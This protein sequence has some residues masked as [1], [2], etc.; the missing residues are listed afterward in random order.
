MRVSHYP[1]AA[2]MFDDAKVRTSK[3]HYIRSM[4]NTNENKQPHS[5]ECDCLHS[6]RTVFVSFASAVG[7]S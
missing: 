1:A 6:C 5:S 3:Q 4:T 2:L 7:T